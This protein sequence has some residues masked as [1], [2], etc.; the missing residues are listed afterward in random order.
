M[1]SVRECAERVM[2]GE[3]KDNANM[4]APS[5][6]DELRS[7]NQELQTVN[8]ELRLKLEAVSRAHHD[9]QNLM[10]ATDFV[11]LLLDSNLCIKQFTDRVTGLFGL[12]PGDE[13]RPISDFTHQLE[14]DDLLKDARAALADLTPIR[15][16]VKSR[17]G[18]WYDV[19][20]RSYRTTGRIDGVVVTFVDITDRQSW[21]Q[22]Q[23]MLLRELTHRV[24]NTLAIVQ[25]IANQT[26][27]HS[28][29]REDFV[30]RFSGRLA[31]LAGAHSLMVQSDW[32]GADFEALA[33]VQLD[34]YAS[35]G[36][37]RLNLQ[38]PPI[39]LPA[40]LATP[41]GLV[42]HELAAN[43]AKYGSLSRDEGSVSLTWD[44]GR[45][46]GE[47]V[48]KVIWKE[49]DGPPVRRAA[50]AGFG[51]ALIEQGIPN[52]K[53]KREFAPEGFVCTIELPVPEAPDGR[54]QAP[55]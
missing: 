29:S 19:F 27:R 11:A 9:L 41:F 42:L 38:G 30:D 39:I 51:T 44:E 26:L 32:Q 40:D 14:Y 23:N 3:N 7:V 47:R 5:R 4:G 13:G 22:R 15:R 8:S 48:L 35:E 20:M 43:A 12:T 50:R 33:R 49:K 53:V 46:R 17:D 55:D 34:P 24:K 21:E 10:A 31:A 52:A 25:S 1:L 37:A 36:M 2:A 54:V 18:R 45:L 6:E 16:E 28:S